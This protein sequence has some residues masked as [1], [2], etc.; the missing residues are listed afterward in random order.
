M[1]TRVKW[2]P[3]ST[4]ERIHVRAFSRNQVYIWTYQQPLGKPKKPKKPKRPRQKLSKTI[5]KT[6][7]NKET[8]TFRPMSAKVDMDLKVCRREHHS[9]NNVSTLKHGNGAL[10]KGI[11]K[12]HRLLQAVIPCCCCCVCWSKLRR[13]SLQY[14]NPQ[15]NSVQLC[16][17]TRK[18]GQDVGHFHRPGNGNR[19]RGNLS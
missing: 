9:E 10:K 11:A 5:E 12:T 14:T 16:Y 4:K 18:P 19:K 2:M 15:Y 7:T 17:V 6:K 3:Y 13:S 1:E 8:K